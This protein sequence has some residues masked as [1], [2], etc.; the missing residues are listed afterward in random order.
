MMSAKFKPGQ[1]IRHKR[2][3]DPDYHTGD[4]DGA[5]LILK[6]C[7]PIEFGSFY[8]EVLLP[9]GTLAASGH[10]YV[11]EVYELVKE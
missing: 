6:V 3:N 4:P 7:D 10:E 2:W 5:I 1:L 8:Y 9:T 11:D